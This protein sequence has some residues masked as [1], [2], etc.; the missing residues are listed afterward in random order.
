[1]ERGFFVLGK[2]LKLIS[3]RFSALSDAL[4]VANFQELNGSIEKISS[5]LH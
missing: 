3:F 1:M 5:N 4:M 2:I